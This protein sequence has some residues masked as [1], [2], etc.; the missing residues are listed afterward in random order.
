MLFRSDSGASERNPK[1]TVTQY[2]LASIIGMSRESTNKQLR[3][4]AA[5]DWVRLQRGGIVITC[6]EALTSIAEGDET[7]P[8]SLQRRARARAM[9]PAMSQPIGHPSPRALILQR[10]A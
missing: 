9:A 6:V 4:W 1:V 7:V 2:D 10:H 5:N 3:S 8:R